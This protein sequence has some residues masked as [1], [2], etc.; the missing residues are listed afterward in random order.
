M[1]G[2]KLEGKRVLKH[3]W[4][5]LTEDHVAQGA[6]ALAFYMALA[7][8]PGAIFGLSVLPLLPVPHLQQAVTDL[9][10]QTLPGAS[11]DVL[12]MSA[13]SASGRGRLHWFSLLFAMWSAASGV[14][15][16]IGQL[17]VVYEVQE[18]R[19]FPRLR[20]LAA[21]LALAFFGLVIAALSLAVFGGMLQSYIGDRLGWS[22][23]LL[24]TFA[25]LRWVVIVS[26]LHFAF[27]LI[28]YL[29][30]NVKH[31][32]TLFTPGSVTATALLL[33]A[34]GAL[35][36]YVSRFPTVNA[37]YGGLGAVIVL[38]V[39]LFLAGWVILFGGELNDVVAREQAR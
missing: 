5:E 16:V 8:F 9:I 26:A 19:S 38:L 3:L 6:A 12:V 22:Q 15:G 33:L 21:L 37:L 14:S 32:F 35:K 36:L 39:W 28:Y 4:H 11:A 1:P 29:G 24:T 27:A 17:N 13:L 18:D 34:S 10:H 25:V 31:P 20:G 30:P 23:T 2:Q 7:L